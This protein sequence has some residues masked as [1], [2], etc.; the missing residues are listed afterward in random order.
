[1]I[2]SA[3]VRTERHDA[4][5]VYS[6]SLRSKTLGRAS[7]AALHT[8]HSP[9][10]TP[11]KNWRNAATGHR[12]PIARTAGRVR[13]NFRNNPSKRPRLSRNIIAAE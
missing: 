11:S 4:D 12:P 10:K 5:Q 9:R 13:R 2:R 6:F 7:A 3:A 8:K 1:M